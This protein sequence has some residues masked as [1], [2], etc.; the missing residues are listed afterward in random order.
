MNNRFVQ[1]T[2]YCIIEY[3]FSDLQG[4]TVLTDDLLVIR[5]SITDLDQVCSVNPTQ[6]TAIQTNNQQ[7]YTVIYIDGNQFVLNDSRGAEQDYAEFS[8]SNITVTE[9]SSQ[10]MQYDIVRL[11]FISGYNFAGYDALI[12]QLRLWQNNQA[13][14]YFANIAIDAGMA[15]N[16]MYF[17]PRPMYITDAF[18]DRYI[19]IHVPSIG[20]VNSRYYNGYL[21]QSQQLGALI[22]PNGDGTYAGLQTAA[23]IGVVLHQCNLGAPILNTND[24]TN[25]YTTYISQ[26]SYQTSI[27]QSSN[28]D[29]LSLYI[30]EATDGD[31]LIYG[32][33]YNGAPIDDFITL[34]N[35]TNPLNN[36]III[37]QLLVYEKVDG[38]NEILTKKL[39][40]IQEDNFAVPNQFRPILQYAG[41]D[42]AFSVDYQCRIMNKLD[43]QQV[44]ATASMTSMSPTKYGK[45][46]QVIQLNGY[47]D[48]YKIYNKI[49][50]SPYEATR[51]FIEPT[52]G[53]VAI[54][55]T[56]SATVNTVTNNVYVPIFINANNVSVSQASSFLTQSN[57]TST[58]IYG[59]GA[60]RLLLTPFDNA[61]QLTFYNTTTGTPTPQ[62]L[63]FGATQFNITFIDD[64]GATMSFAAAYSTDSAT[65]ASGQLSFLIPK[66]S[67]QSLMLYTSR[68]FY[69]TALAAD[70]TETLLYPGFWVRVDEY[71]QIATANTAAQAQASGSTSS[72]SV[73]LPNTATSTTAA[74]TSTTASTT[75]TS[76]PG[77]VQSQPTADQQISPALNAGVDPSQP[78]TTS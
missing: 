37:H 65:L 23:P 66:V 74:T 59:Q 14:C 54:Q 44:L 25:L 8:G 51:Q 27:P 72:T 77:Y 47:P 13:Y 78:T 3:Q 53:A 71:D 35:S 30:S 38:G 57:Q 58:L 26:V 60:I 69:V 48:A 22:T 6:Y 11:H 76:I 31:Y 24:N 5:N 1:I 52:L 68:A 16:T 34:L 19:E 55:G 62:N 40:D 43:G 63:N 10:S 50:K 15:A 41:R 7:D 33:L 39:M 12:F 56:T 75:G 73:M 29:G 49:V 9:I 46:S 4:P 45:S 28:F 2:D 67:S 64:S 18:Y 61:I 17:N 36:W 70:G 32:A 20:N 21:T 42:T